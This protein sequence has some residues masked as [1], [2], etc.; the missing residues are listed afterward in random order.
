MLNSYKDSLP[1]VQTYIDTTIKHEGGD[2]YTDDPNDSGGETKFGVT[3]KATLKYKEYFHLYNWN[4]DIKTMPLSFA[5]DL[6]TYEY[7]MV[8]KFNLVAKES[9]MIAQELFDSG[10][11]VHPKHPSRWLQEELNLCNRRQLDYN[12]IAPDGNIG[13]NTIKALK[14]FLNK[15]GASGEK[16]LYNNLNCCQQHHYRE[17]ALNDGANDKDELFYIGWCLNRLKFK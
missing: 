13:D 17:C 5:Q 12:D 2:K 7:Y 6:Y 15:R 8:P 4:G 14:A 11:N 1:F 3:K 9:E 16:M 10:V